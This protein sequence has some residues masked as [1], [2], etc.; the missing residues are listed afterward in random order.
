[1]ARGRWAWIAA[2]TVT[3]LSLAALADV[4]GD[5]T[6][7]RPEST[8]DDEVTMVQMRVTTRHYKG[9]LGEAAEAAWSACS[10][11]AHGQAE[12]RHVADDRYEIRISPAAG[13]QSRHR[14]EGC[15]E[16]ANTERIRAYTM[17]IGNVPIDQ[18]PPAE[19]ITVE[20]ADARP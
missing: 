1:M 20:D 10:G 13:P 4:V 15:I 2:L 14:I 19:E 3:A 17:S 6:Q 12:L 11:H 16:D 18:A 5:V 8:I 9:D 7:T